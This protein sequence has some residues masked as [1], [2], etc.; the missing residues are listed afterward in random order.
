MRTQLLLL[1]AFS[2]PAV[3][4]N[5]DTS[6]RVPSAAISGVV[7]DSVD[8]GPLAGA[9]VQLVAAAGSAAFARTAVADSLGS[10][11]ISDVPDGRFTIGFF[12]PM[13]DS[14]GLEAPLRE[15]TVAGRRSVRFDLAIPSPARL[16]ATICGQTSGPDSGAVVVGFVR[17]ANTRAPLAG[18]SVTGEWTELTFGPSGVVRHIPRL[19]STTGENGWFAMCNVP[20]AGTIALVAS[21]GADST[22]IIEIQVPDDRFVRADLYLAAASEIV[23]TETANRADSIASLRR[24]IRR[25]SGRLSGTVVTAVGAKP[26]GG[27]EVGIADGPTT[28]A[29]ERGEWTLVGAPLGTRMLEVRA[30]GYYP[31]RRSVNVVAG[32]APVRV[33]LSTFKAV[34]ETVRV[35]ADRL[36]NRES[37]GFLERRR[38]GIGHFLT[39]EDVARRQPVVTSDLF[40]TVPGLT[41]ERSPLGSASIKMRGTFE[42]KCDPAFYIDG[43]YMPDSSADT[44][45]D[46]VHPN[47]V[48]GIEVYTGAGL[49]PQF[50]KGLSG[51]GSIVIWTKRHGS[52]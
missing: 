35:N 36:S 25:G 48:A 50:Q 9:I 2:S 18:V 8:R 29:N 45:D 4:Q 3:A 32:A 34:L 16:Q 28:R 51:C 39:S 38:S 52:S 15:V 6:H 44:I 13:L 41:V 17:D 26:L 1:L 7:Y 31:E 42:Y 47:E 21:R 24:V 43:V 49:P 37:S 14:L 10:F 40:R 30:V 12:H 33:A 27:A 5:P 19:V 11:T 22:D 46:L 23:T 20:G